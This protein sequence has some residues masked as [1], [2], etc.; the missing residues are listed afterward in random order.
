MGGCPRLGAGGSAG[1]TLFPWGKLLP[2][3]ASR[4]GADADGGGGS[5][6]GEVS[7]DGAV[8][9]AATYPGTARLCV[10]DLLAVESA[11]FKTAAQFERTM[12]N[13]GEEP[14]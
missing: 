1:C 11:F 6:A 9:S 14:T 2:Q 10:G 8:A 12:S 3:K 13:R 4:S 5:R 7:P